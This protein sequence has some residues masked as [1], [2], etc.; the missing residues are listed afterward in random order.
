MAG[1]M[2]QADLVTDLKAML[3]DAASRFTDPGDFQRHLETAARDLARVQPLIK[4]ATVTLEA[5]KADYTAPADMVR[6]HAP[7]WGKAEMISKRPWDTDWPGPLP[8]LT[9]ENATLY[10]TPAPTAAQI[11]NLG[12]SYGFRYVAAWAI[13]VTAQDTNIPD[14]L[15]DLLLI[16]AAA[17]AL[18]D[19]CNRNV[20]KPVRLGECGGQPAANGTPAVL[21][22]T[23]MKR[24]ER[25]AA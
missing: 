7:L 16:R 3:M 9:L 1:T 11:T 12:D 2:T 17:A 22:D 4:R 19:L 13:G 14:Y 20:T 6:V 5:D 18:Q 15:R 10:L 23:L 25:M 21:A 8:R 24:F